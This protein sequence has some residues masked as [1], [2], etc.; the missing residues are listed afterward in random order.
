LGYSYLY[1]VYRHF[2][3]FT[4]KIGV[5]MNILIIGSGGREHAIGIEVSQS[6]LCDA[7]F[8]APG[9]PGME[10][11]GTCLPVAADNVEGLVQA[12]QA[13]QIDFTIVGPEQ[14]LVA[15]VVDAF[16][17]HN[18]Q[19]FGP[20]AAAARLEGSKA[21]SK[22]I[23][24]KYKVPTAAYEAF[25]DL[26][27]AQ[28]YISAR[29]GPIVVKASG[30][31]AGKGAIVCENSEQALQAVNDMLGDKA[32][33]GESGK[34]VVIEEMMFG[35]EA[36]LFAVCDGAQYVLLS[37]AQDHKR[38]FDNDEGP[39]TGGMGAYAPAPV[40]THDILEM[41]K[42][43]V[44][45]ATLQGMQQEG[46]AYKGILYVGLMIE[47]TPN[48]KTARVV[49]Y[50]CRL[51]DPEAQI[52]LPLYA[53]DVL[54]LFY[55]ASQGRLNEVQVINRQQSAAIV[56]LAAQGYPG[57]YPKGAPITGISQAEQACVRVIHAGTAMQ[58][59]VLSTNGGRVLGVVGQG[60]DLKAALNSCYAGVGKIKF[61][62]MQYRKDIGKKGLAWVQHD[63]EI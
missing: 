2:S 16:E 4:F 9:N 55:K 50:N 37:S 47:H 27:L 21:F 25:T 3:K 43:D 45:E 12:A 10:Q 24:Q 54:D 59:G 38:I 44:I 36:S 13:N 42:K 32:V 17:Q 41:V 46:C 18:L 15:G 20:S 19:V 39:N 1:N 56:V 5:Y 30:L 33:F 23:M 22:Y 28:Q 35:E 6:P 8:F 62:G 31:A 40:V 57:D 49:E 63:S 26:S 52:V 60:P 58:N 11:L 34:E 48:G 51:G 53:G 61:Q 29:P 7:L 14:P